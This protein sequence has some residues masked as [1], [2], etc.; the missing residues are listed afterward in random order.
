MNK[1]SARSCRKPAGFPGKIAMVTFLAIVSLTGPARPAFSQGKKPD[2]SGHWILNKTKSDFGQGPKVEAVTEDIQQ[3][4]NVLVIKNVTRDPRGEQER[5]L[6]YTTDGA[7]NTNV[8]M[9]HTMKTQSHWEGE[10]LVTVIRDERGMQL[11]E[12]RSLS[13]DGKSQTVETDFGMGKQK[14]VLDKK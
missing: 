13:K 3:N 9:G 1:L 12:T 6:R 11:T 7:E 8:V 5:N 14:L 4:G 10:S 2:F